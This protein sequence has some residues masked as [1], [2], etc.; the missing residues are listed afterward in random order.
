MASRKYQCFNKGTRV[1]VLDSICNINGYNLKYE[2]GTVVDQCDGLRFTNGNACIV[3]FDNK[4]L[5]P[6]ML[7]TK[8]LIKLVEGSFYCDIY[9]V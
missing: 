1:Q 2:H 8:N 4:G 5:K 3:K 6:M 7:Y 9:N